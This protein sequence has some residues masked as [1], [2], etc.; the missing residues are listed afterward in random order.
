MEEKEFFENDENSNQLVIFNSENE[1][2]IEVDYL[3]KIADTVTWS[4][5]WTI[6]SILGAQKRA[7]FNINPGFQR[8]DAWNI[9]KK[10]RFIESL[11]YGLPVPQIVLAEDLNNRSKYLVVDG[12]QRLITIFSFFS[13]DSDIRFSLSGLNSGILN[14]C[15]LKDI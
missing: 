2:D 9:K 4:T 11:I 15:S 5:D 10:S 8:R 14:G 3:K 7:T 13:D 6:E 1:D 12:K